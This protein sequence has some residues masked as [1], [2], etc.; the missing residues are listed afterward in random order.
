[1]ITFEPNSDS[2]YYSKSP[3]DN[4]IKDNSDLAFNSNNPL[5]EKVRKLYYGK[6]FSFQIDNSMKQNKSEDNSN[7]STLDDLEN[8]KY[9]AE[10]DL[11]LQDSLSNEGDADFNQIP[12]RS[13]C[14]TWPRL[15]PQQETSEESKT[16]NNYPNVDEIKVE[17]DATKLGDRN[18]D[19]SSKQN[20]GQLRQ[21][22]NKT[23]NCS[24]DTSNVSASLPYGYL[25]GNSTFQ[26]PHF[27]VTY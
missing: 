21:L 20:D 1:M 22:L 14:N 19:S 4:K 13:R 9:S 12:Y 18:D 25:Q 11:M 8:Y 27:I 6:E 15:Q 26:Q 23:S 7:N 16:P 5:N 17:N 2:N 24:A 3:K 10:F